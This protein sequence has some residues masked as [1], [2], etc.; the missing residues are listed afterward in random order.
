MK[1]T[2]LLLKWEMIFGATLNIFYELRLFLGKNY[3]D[4]SH[5]EMIGLQDY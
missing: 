1:Q 4:S 2:Y 3:A 5:E